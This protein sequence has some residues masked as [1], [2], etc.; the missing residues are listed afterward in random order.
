MVDGR[1][2]IVCGGILLVLCQEKLDKAHGIF[3]RS[4]MQGGAHICASQSHLIKKINYSKRVLLQTSAFIMVLRTRCDTTIQSAHPG[5]LN[6][7]NWS[8]Q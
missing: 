4:V 2:T 5:M 8:A 7:T 3:P 6:A 1:I